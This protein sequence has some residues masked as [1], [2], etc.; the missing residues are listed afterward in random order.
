[1]YILVYTLMVLH[2]SQALSYAVMRHL[3]ISNLTCLRQIFTER[4]SFNQTFLV[5]NNLPTFPTTKSA[6]GV[7]H[8]AQKM[9]TVTKRS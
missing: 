2:H 5:E 7:V 8:S 4:T 6:I 1:M 9:P 3:E